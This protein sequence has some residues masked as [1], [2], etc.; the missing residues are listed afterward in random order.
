MFVSLIRANKKHISPTVEEVKYT[1]MAVESKNSW[2][3]VD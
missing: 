2:F 1:D 3:V